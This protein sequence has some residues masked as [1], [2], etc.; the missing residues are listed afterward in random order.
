MPMPAC[1]TKQKE[2]LQI[3]FVCLFFFPPLICNGYPLSISGKKVMFGLYKNEMI[4]GAKLSVFKK[5][6]EILHLQEAL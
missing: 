4:I 6:N 2:Q 5:P 3:W 1:F